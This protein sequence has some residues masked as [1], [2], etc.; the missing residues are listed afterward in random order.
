MITFHSTSLTTL[1]AKAVLFVMV[2]TASFAVDTPGVA[3]QSIKVSVDQAQIMRLST[4]ASTII[5]GNPVIADVNI[6]DGRLLIVMG[7]STGATNMIALDSEGREIANINIIVHSNGSNSMTL[8]KGSSRVSMN[9]SPNCERTLYVGDSVPEF[10]K[11]EKQII[12]KMNTI[13][14]AADF[15]N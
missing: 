15:S 7:K 11:I 10:E 3:A 6:Q 8:Y 4:E 14:A 2:L 13:K 5:V 1:L 9:C 12:I